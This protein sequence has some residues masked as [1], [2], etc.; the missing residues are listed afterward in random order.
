MSVCER[1]RWPAR[2]ELGPQ[3]GVVVDLAVEDDPDRPVLVGH[4]LVAGGREVDDRQ[5]AMAER[6]AGRSG[7][8]TTPASSGPRWRSVSAMRR[9]VASSAAKSSVKASAPAIPHMSASA[10]GRQQLRA[11][12]TYGTVRSKDLHVASTATSWRRRGS[13]SSTISWSGTRAEPRICQWPVMPGVRCSRRRCQPCDLRVLVDDQ[14]PRPDQA[15]LAA[16]HVDELRQLVERRRAQEPPDARDARIVGDL[17]E[18]VGLVERAR[19]PPCAP[20]RR[21]PSC[22]T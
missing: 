16:Q 3:R 9:T 18:P 12:N 4:R 20:R 2:L 6:D 13:R 17:E 7:S 1:K 5:A 22:G 19:A 10:R 11:P 21:R 14:R 15:H 8:A